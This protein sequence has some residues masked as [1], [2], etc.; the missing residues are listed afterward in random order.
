MGYEIE[1]PKVR[2]PPHL[3]EAALLARTARAEDA[4]VRSADLVQ[5]VW[6]RFG[7][8]LHSRTIERGLLRDQEKRR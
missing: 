7:V 5:K 3:G 4:E 1:G 8:E 6:E 2:L